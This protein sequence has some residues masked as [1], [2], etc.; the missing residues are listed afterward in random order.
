M[1]LTEYVQQVSREDFGWEFRHEAHWNKRLRTTGGRFFPKDGHLDFNPKIYQAYGLEV[2]RR[3]VRHELV[4]YHLYY[5]GKGYRHQDADFKRLLA[6]VDGL[7]FAP[8]L[9]QN[10][11]NQI[12]QCQSCGKIYQRKRR[13]DTRKYRCGF[14]RG[15]LKQMKT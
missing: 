13:L 12:Y 14:C 9:P 11:P 7:R 8:A 4:H 3:I 6:Q 15:V 10:K 1:N 5:Q 2:F